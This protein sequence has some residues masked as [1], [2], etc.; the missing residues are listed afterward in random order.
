[1]FSVIN[2]VLLR[3]L[4]Y[5]EPHHLVRVAR[6]ANQDALTAMEFSF[7]KEHRHA[8]SSMAGYRGA[9]DHHLIAGNEQEWIKSMAVTRD[10]LRLWESARL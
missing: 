1:M 3:S 9:S 2:A 6:S 10:F 7:W 8:F 4:P 5:P